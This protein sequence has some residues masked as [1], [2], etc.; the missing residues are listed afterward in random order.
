MS[1][2]T[3]PAPKRSGAARRPRPPRAIAFPAGASCASG[4][5]SSGSIRTAARAG[6]RVRESRAVSGRPPKGLFVT[7][8]GIEGSG[9]STQVGARHA[10]RLQA[11]ASPVA[12]DTRARR[13]DRRRGLRDVLLGW[14][15]TAR[16]GR[17]ASPDVR[18]PAAAPLRDDR[19]RPRR[20]ARRSLRPVHRRL[21]RLSGGGTGAR[22]GNRRRSST[23]VLPPRE[24]RDVPRSTAPS[25]RRSRAS[26]P[27]SGGRS[28]P[29]RARGSRVPPACPGGLPAPRAARAE[30]L[31]PARRAARARTRSSPRS[32]T[33]S[34]AGSTRR[35]LLP[36]GTPS[37]RERIPDAAVVLLAGPGS[38]RLEAMALAEAAHVVCRAG[39]LPGEPAEDCPDCRRVRRK[40]HPDVMV[41]APE[42]A[43]RV[44]P[45]AVR[46]DVRLEGDDDS[47][48][49]RPR[50]R[51]RRDPP[52]VR[53]AAAGPSSCST[54]TGPSPP[55]TAP[56][57]RFS[58]S[59]RPAHGSF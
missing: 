6:I 38:R 53:G 33:I 19:A 50:A 34:R 58:K 12:R 35:G 15:G 41:A 57:S 31:R 46:G 48:R 26:P 29:V 36:R 23:D 24:R 13:H 40:E 47:D 9:K 21:A 14:S 37:V 8:E 11:S 32:G 2:P 43:R 1:A 51:R 45:P 56:S 42:S 28:R 10:V 18:R 27:R 25:R 5:A 30:A 17:R 39:H 52:S 16:P 22:R 3:R 59:R 7:F 44:N 4:S 49:S 55:P 54:S 20:R